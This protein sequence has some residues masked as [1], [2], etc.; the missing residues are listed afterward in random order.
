MRKVF[1]SSEISETTLVRDALLHAGVAV[2]I[3]NEHSGGSA[4]PAFRPPAEV[5]IE[6]D[7]DY[8]NAR[9]I[10][11]DTILTLNNKSDAKP[12][13]CLD[14]KEQNPQSFDVCWNCGRDRGRND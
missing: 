3:Q 1:S 2:T 8:E 12:W 4:I 11:I 7:G 6:R 10:V 13:G 9:R 5:W 14:C